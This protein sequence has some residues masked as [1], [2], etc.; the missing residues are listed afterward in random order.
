MLLLT[1]VLLISNYQVAEPSGC[2][3]DSEASCETKIFSTRLLREYH[4][5]LLADTRQWDPDP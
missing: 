2:L 3:S 5:L 4:G 1:K